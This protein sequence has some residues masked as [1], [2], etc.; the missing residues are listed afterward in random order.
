MRKASL[1]V[2]ILLLATIAAY[3]HVL[4]FRGHAFWSA[5]F[6]KGDFGT[7]FDAQPPLLAFKL[8]GVPTPHWM[9]LALALVAWLGWLARVDRKEDSPYGTVQAVAGVLGLALNGILLVCMLILTRKLPLASIA[10]TST[11]ALVS[12][13]D[14]WWVRSLALL[15]QIRM[16]PRSLWPTGEG[17][18][19]RTGRMLTLVLVLGT[20]WLTNFSLSLGGPT[21]GFGG[22]QQVDRMGTGGQAAD[23]GAEAPPP[24]GKPISFSADE[25]NTALAYGPANAPVTIVEF[26]DLQCGFCAKGNETMNQLLARY[27]GKIRIVHKHFPLDFHE[28]ASLAAAALEAAGEQGKFWEY[29][30]ELFAKTSAGASIARD[31]LLVSA[32]KTGLDLARF[33]RALE[34]NPYKSKIESDVAL[35][36]R[37]GVS[38]TPCFFING[39]KVDGARP[40]SA[41]AALID[42]ELSK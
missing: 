18:N 11:L 7:F 34:A 10:L 15:P 17:E 39:G 20:V 25:L 4:A 28:N 31:A 2:S 16:L 42:R 8:L 24:S 5:F 30:N 3:G 6:A 13:M 29:R 41:F 33:T 26:S 22:R 36:K 9:L 38:G 40:I 27:K 21:E 19:E 14:G 32:K 12:I 23:P 1:S 37:L 35:G